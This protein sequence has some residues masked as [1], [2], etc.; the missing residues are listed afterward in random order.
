MSN[1]QTIGERVIEFGKSRQSFTAK[2]VID[3]LRVKRTSVSGILANMVIN[4]Q[5][6][7]ADRRTYRVV[8]ASKAMMVERAILTG[9]KA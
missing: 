9:V 4:G 3:N 1:Y 2:D 6:I 7:K 5:L 8:E